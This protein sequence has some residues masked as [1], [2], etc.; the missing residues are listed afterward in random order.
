MTKLKLLAGASIMGAVLMSSV[1]FAATTE[2][3]AGTTGTPKTE[4][5]A[6]MMTKKTNPKMTADQKACVK[7]AKAT[8]ADMIK[9]AATTLTQALKDARAM[10]DKAAVKVAKAAAK[11]AYKD[12]VTD[13][14][15]TY[16]GAYASCVK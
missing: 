4:M 9:T 11:K 1:A 14:K 15:I 10:T 5:G 8:K 3:T 2:M 6:K 12:A 7:T 16:K 13:A